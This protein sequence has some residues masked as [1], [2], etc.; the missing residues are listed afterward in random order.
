MVGKYILRFLTS[1]RISFVDKF[2]KLPHVHPAGGIVL[3]L[4]PSQLPPG[5]AAAVLLGIG[6]SGKK[7]TSSRHVR[8]VRKRTGNRHKSI[9]SRLIQTGN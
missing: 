2:T 7:G 8:K 9:F 3:A 5:L 4:D 6:A 1:S